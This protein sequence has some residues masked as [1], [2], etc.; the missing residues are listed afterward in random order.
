MALTPTDSP[1]AT[2]SPQVVASTGMP[3]ARRLARARRSGSPATSTPSEFGA[4]GDAFTNA[5]K[6]ATS[7]RQVSAP[8]SFAGSMITENMLLVMVPLAQLP[9]CMVTP[10]VMAP[11]SNSAITARP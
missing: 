1:A 5:V 6:A 8:P 7:W 11:A 3:S 9:S 4:F 2:I 10:P